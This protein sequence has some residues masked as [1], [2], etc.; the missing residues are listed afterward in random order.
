MAERERERDEKGIF[1]RALKG[2]LSLKADERA[3]RGIESERQCG[4]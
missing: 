2:K 4:E 3:S 1:G